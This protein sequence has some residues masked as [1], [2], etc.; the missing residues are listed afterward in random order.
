MFMIPPTCLY[1]NFRNASVRI[2]AKM[3]GPSFSVS[4]SEFMV[5]RQRTYPAGK[6]FGDYKPVIC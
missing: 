6:S 5:N 2:L 4:C 3:N 1:K